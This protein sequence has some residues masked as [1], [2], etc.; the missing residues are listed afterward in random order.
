MKILLA[1]AFGGGVGA[2]ARYLGSH[3][4]GHWLGTGLPWATLGVNIIGS[5]A[6]GVLIELSALVWSPSPALRAFLTVGV[7]ASFTT[8]STFSMDVVLL[9]E[10][11]RTLMAVLY[12]AISTALAV[13]GLLAGMRAV[14][15]I[16][17]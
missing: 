1:V 6:L 14:R 12:V 8:F 5:V 3:Q 17:I 4:I 2:V 11:G 7:L 15:V 10:R 16:L 13:G 9:A